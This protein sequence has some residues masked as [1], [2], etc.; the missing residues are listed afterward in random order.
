MKIAFSQVDT[1]LDFY[2][3]DL[4]NI[5][6]PNNIREYIR[7]NKAKDYQ[8][9]ITKKNFNSD[10][11][12]E[13]TVSILLLLFRDYFANERQ[14]KIIFDW[15]E[16]NNTVSSIESNIKFKNNINNKCE[17]IKENK[18]LPV[19]KSNIFLKIINKIKLMFR[20]RGKNQ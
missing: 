9:D 8:F 3:Q 18:L 7:N 20:K 15:E 5:C 6:I 1:I 17:D 11:L 4:L 19:K 2:N 13:E 12:T 16:H 14:R 10:M